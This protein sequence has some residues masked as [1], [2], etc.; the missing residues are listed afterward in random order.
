DTMLL[1]STINHVIAGPGAEELSFEDGTNFVITDSGTITIDSDTGKTSLVSDDSNSGGSDTVNL[2]NGVN[3]LITGA[4]GDVV[5]STSTENDSGI[6]LVVADLGEVSVSED[7]TAMHAKSLERTSNDDN[8]SWETVDQ[9]TL[10]GG[11]N[12]AIAGA[13]RDELSITGGSN[14][15]ISDDGEIVLTGARTVETVSSTNLGIG[16]RDVISI[17]DGT[18]YVIAGLGN[19]DIDVGGGTNFVHGEEGKLEV[20]SD[21][22]DT[23][24]ITTLNADAGTDADIDDIDIGAGFN[25]VIGGAAGDTI[26]VNGTATDAQSYVIGDSGSITLQTSTGNLLS[27]ES[28]DYEYGGADVINLITG[29]NAVIGGASGDEI[30]AEA[31]TNTILGDAGKATF[32]ADGTLQLIESTNL[33]TGARDTIVLSDGTNHVIAGLGDDDIDVGGGTNFV[34]GEEGKLEVQSDGSDTTLITT[35]NAEAGTDA[36]IDDIDIGAGFNV[37]IGGAAG[38][39]V[40][41]NGTATDAQSYVIGDSGSITLQTST[42]NL[43]SIESTEYDYGGA[44]VINL[45]AGTNAVIGGA[46]GDEISAEAGTNTILGDAGKATFTA[47]GTLQLI[48]STNLGTGARDTIVLSDG[49]NHVIAGL[50]DDDIDVGGGTNFVH[51]EEGKLEVQSDGSDTTLITTLNAEAGTDADID[52]IDIGAGFNVVIGGAA[53]DTVDVNGTA[54]DA[55]SYVIG[56]NGSITLQTSTGNLLSIESTDYAYGGAD[57]INLL[58]GTNAVIGGVS[59]DI[60]T[61]QSGNNTILGDAGKADFATDGTLQSI[62]STDLG[63]GGDDSIS[64][65]EGINYVVAGADVSGDT[66]VIDGGTNIVHG[67]EARVQILDDGS[68]TTVVSTLNANTVSQSDTTSLDD[69]ITING[70]RNVVLGGVASDSIIVNE[71]ATQSRS[72]IMGDSGQITI[73]TSTTRVRKLQS[74]DVATGDSDV[75]NISAGVNTVI[76]GAGGDDIHVGSNDG[77]DVILGDSGDV[78]FFESSDELINEIS[79]S[80]PSSG[81]DDQISFGGGDDIVIAGFGSDFIN[82]SRDGDRIEADTGSDIVLGDSGKVT[83]TLDTTNS[84]SVISEIGTSDPEHGGQDLIYSANG[85]DVIFGGSEGDTIE[86]GSD[87][88]SDIAVGDNGFALFDE[89]G[90]LIEVSTGDHAYGGSDIITTGSATDYVIGGDDGDTITT[91]GGHD[92]VLGDTGHLT[93]SQDTNPPTLVSI[94]SPSEDTEHGG[95]DTIDTGE[96]ND[97]A[98]GGTGSDALFGRDG[99]D[100]LSNYQANVTIPLPTPLTVSRWG[101]QGI[102]YL[103]NQEMSLAASENFTSLN[104]GGDSATGTGTPVDSN[105]RLYGE[106]GDDFY[107][108]APGGSDIIDESVIDTST[109][110]D[111]DILRSNAEDILDAAQ[112]GSTGYDTISFQT[113]ERGITFD[114]DQLDEAQYVVDPVRVNIEEET[115]AT[116][117]LTRTDPLPARS[118]YE[119]VIGTAYKDVVYTDTLP[120]VRTFKGGN[121]TTG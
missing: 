40:D 16:N 22:S 33:G 5:T 58:T 106:D 118:A 6:N 28:T 86:G 43:L 84:N 42:G 113:S 121:P 44:D 4:M 59:G 17:S 96:G 100:V 80:Y 111:H 54:T 62:E 105:N 87:D 107:L 11:T 120:V 9:I 112:G 74:T 35:L 45:I 102:R 92:I 50:G 55:Q 36:D 109:I 81:G 103:W 14:T 1:S 115:P 18:N 99:H 78:I 19:D 52:D 47:D 34:H 98:F 25:V 15:I 91:T 66:V 27:I 101:D 46:S 53:G 90:R 41:V 71:G 70:G 24:L 3:I 49:T 76:G 61:A 114:P 12:I 97:L 69:E 88:S 31:G 116:V 37:V 32:T 72:S 20:Q 8:A 110:K 82:Y 51:G 10:H 94:T 56:D 108:I 75:I 21:G 68:D 95:D 83:F 29:T 104:A 26:D 119:N 77:R 89:Q 13:G 65:G 60:I 2:G 57:V 48:E 7:L 67:D 30:S 73:E 79:S 64:L 117:T 63:S 85:S 23:T 38:D 39:T 93:W